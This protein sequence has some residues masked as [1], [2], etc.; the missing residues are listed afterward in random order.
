MLIYAVW[1]P[2]TTEKKT[3]KK[4]NMLSLR[5]LWRLALA[6]PTQIIQTQPKQHMRIDSLM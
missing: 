1:T 2:T 3:N 6:E 4:K 5:G